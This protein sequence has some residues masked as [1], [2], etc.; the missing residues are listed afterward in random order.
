MLRLLKS[1]FPGLYCQIFDVLQAGLD[2]C[3]FTRDYLARI[4]QMLQAPE[5][6]AIKA[7]RLCLFISLA[8]PLVQIFETDTTIL[9]CF[10]QRLNCLVYN[11]PK[12]L[13]AEQISWW[14]TIMR[15]AAEG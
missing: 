11:P 15:G 7:V 2:T 8:G 13:S 1:N 9:H 3:F 12:G 14:Q 10:F 5:Q 4:D 6:P